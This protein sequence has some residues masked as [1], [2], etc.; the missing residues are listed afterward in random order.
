MT[1]R[2]LLLNPGWFDDQGGPWYCPPGAV[3]EGVLAFHP[4]LR[5]ALDITYLDHPRPRPAVIELVGVRVAYVLAGVVFVLGARV[6]LPVLRHRGEG[7]LIDER[8]PPT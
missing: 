6:L 4:V 1:D 5:E 3:I 8:L 7:S 2:L